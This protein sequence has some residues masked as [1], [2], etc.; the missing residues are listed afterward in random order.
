MKV[1]SHRYQE[2]GN[3]QKCLYRHDR[4]F[5]LR[6][7]WRYFAAIIEHLKMANQEEIGFI[8]EAL[9]NQA[10]ERISKNDT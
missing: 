6:P 4:H 7:F 10:N 5:D 8:N 2:N 3:G 9:P 1:V